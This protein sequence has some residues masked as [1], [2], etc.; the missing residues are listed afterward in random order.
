MICFRSRM[1]IFLINHVANF[2]FY[3]SPE[4]YNQDD[5]QTYIIF[6][7][8]ECN[9]LYKLALLILE[10]LF[11]T[12]KTKRNFGTVLRVNL[13]IYIILRI[14]YNRIAIWQKTIRHV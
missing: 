4:H 12:T 1:S 6:N 5:Y 11:C 13:L 9:N 2:I 14:T 10:L 3:L 7:L 8:S